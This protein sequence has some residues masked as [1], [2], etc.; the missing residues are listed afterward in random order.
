MSQKK[1]N[2]HSKRTPEP[3]EVHPSIQ[4]A[5]QPQRREENCC[6]VC[7]QATVERNAPQEVRTCHTKRW[8]LMM[9]DCS[10][11]NASGGLLIERHFNVQKRDVLTTCCSEKKKYLYIYIY[12]IYDDIWWYMY[13]I[14]L[15]IVVSS[16]TTLLHPNAF[17][18]VLCKNTNPPNL[19]PPKNIMFH[20]AGPPIFQLWNGVS[21]HSN[22]PINGHMKLGNWGQKTCY[23]P[24]IKMEYLVVST[25]LK[26]MLVKLDHLPR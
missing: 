21:F 3:Q 26:N 25:H 9:V 4:H 20:K 2:R 5:Q 18:G 12:M 11:K 1:K 8:W 6:P 17:W 14:C 16:N 13:S 24:P 15:I 10:R 19:P 23:S 7:P 22:S